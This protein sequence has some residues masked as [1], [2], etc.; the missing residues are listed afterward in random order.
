M[1]IDFHTHIFSPQV[2]A[3]RQQYAENDPSFGLLYAD[4]RAKL[5]TAEQLIES[6]DKADIDMSVILNIG[7]MEHETCVETNDYILESI[8]KY[9]KRLV[10]FCALQPNSPEAS[11]KEIER[12]AKA[13][14]KGF[15]EIRPDMQMIDFNAPEVLSPVFDA[16]KQHNLILL[17]HSSEPI[18][19]Y[20]QGKG[21]VTPD[22]LSAMLT[23]YPELKVVC[24]HWGGG[25]PFYALMPE[26]KKALAN[27]Y[28]DSAASPFLYSAQV[29][30]IVA[31]LVGADKILFGTDY[32]LLAQTRLI[33]Q[34]KAADLPPESKDLILGGN[35]VRLLD[36]RA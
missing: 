12:C 21:A 27:A 3:E 4:H 28:F 5:I 15:G 33:D 19:H 1:I 36:L 35:A 20:Y 16:L 31:K 2:I 10:G 17:T 23:N 25:L 14:A 11:V 6:M 32:P 29:W 8:A 7:W 9:P 24:A 22:V 26:V 30:E 34:I 13:G 18:G